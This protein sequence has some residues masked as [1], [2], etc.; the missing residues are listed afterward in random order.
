MN[1]QSAAAP[2][3]RGNLTEQL[4]AKLVQDIH[5]GVTPPG[6][7]LPTENELCQQ[8]N[9]S[10][11]VV[12]EAISRL[13]SDGLVASRQGAG[14]FVLKEST[15]RPFRIEAPGASI[16]DIM[17]ISELRMAFDVEA[18]A[19]AARRRS[20][21]HLKVMRDALDAMGRAVAS[22]SEVGTEGDL[23]FHRAIA[24]ATGNPLYQSFFKFLEPFVRRAISE[25]RSRS[26]RRPGMPERVHREHEDLYA[27]IL[28]K[29]P[30]AAA[31]AAR[32]NIQGGMKRLSTSWTG[33]QPAEAVTA[34]RP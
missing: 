25:A 21:K 15:D 1:R 6:T 30:D 12:R 13:K 33:G 28:A 22:G 14:V 20:Q 34:G 31:V 2:F 10:R 16:D 19:L 27:A 18:A 24:E 11:T 17:H 8:F 4:A 29:D 32:R 5:D 9:V 3:F 26:Q 23:D 7:R